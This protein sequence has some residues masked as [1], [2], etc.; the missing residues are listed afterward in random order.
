MPTKAHMAAEAERQTRA[1]VTAQTSAAIAQ[2]EAFAYARRDLFNFIA[3]QKHGAI[4]EEVVEAFS[5]DTNLVTVLLQAM[6][7]DGD[8]ELYQSVYRLPRGAA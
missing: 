4:F 8:I 3:S 5:R 7:T 6:L 2:A 1:A